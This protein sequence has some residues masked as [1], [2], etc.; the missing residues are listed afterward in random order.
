M[1]RPLPRWSLTAAGGL[2]ETRITRTED[3]ALLGK[4]FQRSPKLSAS[5]SG[6][7]RPDDQLRLSAQ[8]RH[9]GAYFSND[10]E[11]E[12]LRIRGS[13]TIDAR[14]SWTRGGLTL[15][16]YARNLL[17]EFHLT[18]LFPVAP[19]RSQ[20]AT[21]GDPRELGIGVEMRF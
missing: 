7:W 19:S 13:T 14:A 3:L 6:D 21:A 16:G 12:A 9:N 10:A 17:D 5:L 11:T 15:S 1:W 20:L 4:T 2:L 18:Y 8:V